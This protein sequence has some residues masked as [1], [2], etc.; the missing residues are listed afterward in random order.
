MTRHDRSDSPKGNVR[1]LV[2][3]PVVLLALFILLVVAA[4]LFLPLIMS[5]MHRRPPSHP[6]VGQKLPAL[7]LEPLTGDSQPVT[8]DDLAGKVV[9]INFWGTWCPPC[10]EELPD[11]VALDKK[12]RDRAD[13]RLLAVSCGSGGET[14][15]DVLRSETA[16]IL[17]FEQIDMPTYTDPQQVTRR[18]L[19]QLGGFDGYPTT[20]VLDRD[21]V[22]RG[23]WAGPATAEE[24]D[25]Q[26]SRLLT[27]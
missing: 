15:P 19:A 17:D 20:V 12:Y 6:A 26:I 4:F 11:I 13:F 21:G 10:R 1:L 2:I 9:L 5:Q 16:A 7:Q 25:A 22:I 23:L 24:L 14:D 18:A 27:Q 8:L 3:L